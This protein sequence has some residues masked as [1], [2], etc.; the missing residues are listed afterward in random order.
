MSSRPIPTELLPWALESLGAGTAEQAALTMIAG[1]ASN[2]RYFRLAVACQS[3]ITVDAPPG[4]EKNAEFVAVR[5]MLANA[6]VR[7][8]ALLAVDLTRGFMLLE[9]L[10]DQMLLPALNS[11]S[12]DGYYRSAFAVLRKMAAVDRAGLAMPEY[13]RALLGEELSRFDQ[14]FVEALLGYSLADSEKAMIARLGKLLLDSALEQP[15]VLVHRDFHSRNLMLVAE[16]ELAAIDFQDAVIGP[17]TYDLVS[18]L[19]DCYIRWPADRVRQWALKY[20][21]SLKIAPVSSRTDSEF[22]RWFDWMGLQRHIKVLGTFAR[23]NLSDG[24]TGYLE[25]LP[26]VIHY[27]EETLA[28]YASEEPAFTEFRD[29][30]TEKLSPL[31][32]LQA[33]SARS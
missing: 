28:Q 18:L 10:G 11:H 2:R 15:R 23:L 22:L 14:W 7:V 12:V 30:F 19:K 13:D 31:I 20:R 6:G 32:L 21:N 8:P 4:T 9:D 3:Y 24:K 17:V 29:W 5:E 16:G 33:W 25:D 26:L 1:D 27:V